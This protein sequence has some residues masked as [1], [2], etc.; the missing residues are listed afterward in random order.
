M[1][2]RQVGNYVCRSSNYPGIF[3]GT[4]AHWSGYLWS[5]PSAGYSGPAAIG[6][7]DHSSNGDFCYSGMGFRVTWKYCG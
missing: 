3:P 1:P 2:P 4:A 6:D 7:Y 5:V